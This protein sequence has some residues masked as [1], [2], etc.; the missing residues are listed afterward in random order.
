MQG[1]KEKRKFIMAQ[2]PMETTCRDFWKMVYERNCGSIVMLSGM[3]E[4]DEVSVVVPNQLVVTSHV[5]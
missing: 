5:T 1:Y 4:N 3:T 2:G